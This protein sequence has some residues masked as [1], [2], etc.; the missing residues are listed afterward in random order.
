MAKDSFDLVADVR[1]LLNVPAITTLLEPG[2]RVD[3][4]V[5]TTASTVKGIVVNSL[6]I[7]YTQDQ[8]GFGNINCYAPAIPS[9]INGK[10]V[11][12]PDQAYLSTLAKQVTKLIDGVYASTFR[13]WVEEGA[14][15]LQDTDGSY[16]A[17]IRFRYQSIQENYKNI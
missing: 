11:L 2:G 7:T 8:I 6:G 12:L 14:L 3:P 17:N 15:I 1:G 5:K 13:V 10:T 4:S 9:T 16:F